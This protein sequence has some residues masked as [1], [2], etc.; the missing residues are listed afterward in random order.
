M[1][2]RTTTA[3]AALPAAPPTIVK[4]TVHGLVALDYALHNA[5]QS[6]WGSLTSVGTGKSLDL[7]RR[8]FSVLEVRGTGF[9]NLVPTLVQKLLRSRCRLSDPLH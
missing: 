3:P 8:T 1:P 9:L 2:P 7:T 4:D 5:I 6:D